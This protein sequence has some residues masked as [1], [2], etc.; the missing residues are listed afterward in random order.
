[1]L[2]SKG[3][4]EACDQANPEHVSTREK[5]GWMER[6]ERGGGGEGEGLGAEGREREG[7]GEG[8]RLGVG[9]KK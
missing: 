8:E 3:D 9:G 5:E 4:I 1:M 7:G 2:L 6:R